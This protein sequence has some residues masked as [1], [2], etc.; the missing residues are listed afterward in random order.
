MFDMRGQDTYQVQDVSLAAKGLCRLAR[1]SEEVLRPLAPILELHR[2]HR[3]RGRV[4]E[5]LECRR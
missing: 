3:L 2:S 1:R 5:L 4:I